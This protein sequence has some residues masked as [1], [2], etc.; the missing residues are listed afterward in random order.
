M[1]SKKEH[2]NIR[3]KYLTDHFCFTDFFFFTKIIGQILDVMAQLT[4]A[5]FAVSSFHKR[6]TIL[7]TPN[8]RGS[9]RFFPFFL[10]LLTKV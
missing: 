2:T 5:A 8:K 1:L 3:A 10:T 7:K 6:P 9:Y 4:N